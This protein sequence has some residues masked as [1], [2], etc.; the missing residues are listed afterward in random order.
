MCVCKGTDLNLD[1]DL[2]VFVIYVIKVCLFCVCI[3]T[4]KSSFNSIGN[5]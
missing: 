2:Y 1:Q 4:N 5:Q 3:V